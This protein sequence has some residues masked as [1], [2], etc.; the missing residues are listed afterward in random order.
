M[1][2]QLPFRVE[3]FLRIKLT[4]TAESDSSNDVEIIG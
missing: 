4:V 2:G 1:E 3:S